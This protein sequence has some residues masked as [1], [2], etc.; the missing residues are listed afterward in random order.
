MRTSEGRLRRPRGEQL[1]VE[2]AGLARAGDAG[3]GA[4]HAWKHEMLQ[5]AV[6][7]MY[8]RVGKPADVEGA[9]RR[10]SSVERQ[11]QRAVAAERRSAGV[12][13]RAQR[14]P[15]AAPDLGSDAVGIAEHALRVRIGAAA[16]HAAVAEHDGMCST[17]RSR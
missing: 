13:V 7:S 3:F 16:D 2:H 12:Q 6:H 4:Q 5:A 17:A 15:S 8:S 11:L 14:A 9:L 1:E 10:R